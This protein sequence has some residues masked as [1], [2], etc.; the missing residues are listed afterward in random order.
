MNK[1]NMT[2]FKINMT[3]HVKNSNSGDKYL[4]VTNHK[5]YGMS[6]IVCEPEFFS[7]IAERAG[8]R[9]LSRTIQKSLEELKEFISD[10]YREMRL[11]RKDVR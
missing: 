8:E 2:D 5:S 3:T 9:T 11:R 1:V 7:D 10:R 6:F 4:M